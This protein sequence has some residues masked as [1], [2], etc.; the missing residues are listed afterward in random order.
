VSL[1]RLERYKG[2]HRVLE[3]FAALHRDFPGA[4]LRILG[5]GPYKPELVR[6]VAQLKLEDCVLVGAIPPKERHAMANLLAGTALVVLFSEY[7]AHPVAVM[8]A[9]S[10]GVSVL[11]SDTSGFREM[12]EKGLVRAIPIGS[13]ASEISQAM[14]SGLKSTR[15]AADISLPTWDDCADQLLSI[16]NAARRVR[17][18][19][20]TSISDGSVIAPR[21]LAE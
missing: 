5:E 9:L 12:A 1:G 7:E 3:A 4:R 6:L 8:E 2:H 20:S 18:S 15:P 13:S 16:Y 14:A 10:L 19:T 17:P 21:G 11:T